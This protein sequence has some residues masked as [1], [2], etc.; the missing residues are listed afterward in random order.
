MPP[1]SQEFAH[2]PRRSEIG[3]AWLGWG[4]EVLCDWG[5][6]HA[7]SNKLHQQGGVQKVERVPVE[8]LFQAC[9]LLALRRVA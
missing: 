1:G 2:E 7:R 6:T 3:G 4:V 9:V 5:V 8:W